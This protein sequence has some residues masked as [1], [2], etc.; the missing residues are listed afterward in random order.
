MKIDPNLLPKELRPRPV[1]T[2]VTAILLVI[3]VLLGVGAYAFYQGKSDANRD[4]DKL[5]AQKAALEKKTTE[6]LQN[7]DV[8]EL[9]TLITQTQAELTRQE[10]T[11]QDYD[12]FMTSRVNWD[13]VLDLVD[14]LIPPGGSL[15]SIKIQGN[16][17][18][19]HGKTLTNGDASDYAFALIQQQDY[20]SSVG[21]PTL[22]SDGKTI[23]FSLSLEVKSGG[24]SK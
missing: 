9:Q 15:D 16:T 23:T 12:L 2:V 22:Q 5:E 19:L 18:A 20:F 21:S 13:K 8:V 3:I 1:I 14:Y 11:K 17:L 6:V 4:V 7:P 24:D 10:A